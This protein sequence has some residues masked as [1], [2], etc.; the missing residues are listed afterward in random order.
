MDFF[1]DSESRCLILS[2][3]DLEINAKVSGTIN[4]YY[5]VLP[6]AIGVLTAC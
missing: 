3:H 4:K 1:Q 6:Q 5:R 2:I